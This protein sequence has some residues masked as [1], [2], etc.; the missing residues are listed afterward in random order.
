M[1]SSGSGG[2]LLTP[3]GNEGRQMISSCSRP[4]MPSGIG[5]EPGS[6]LL[7]TFVKKCSDAILSQSDLPFYTSHQNSRPAPDSIR[8]WGR[9]NNIIWQWGRR[10]C[11]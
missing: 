1:A 7:G 9:T 11:I 10:T 4:L 2:G 3:S 8:N 5:G 6:D